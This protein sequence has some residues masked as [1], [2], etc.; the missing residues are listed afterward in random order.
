MARSTTIGVSVAAA[1]VLAGC[2]SARAASE[3]PSSARAQD[4]AHEHRWISIAKEYRQAVRDGDMERVDALQAPDARIWFGERKGDGRALDP[5]GRGPWAQWDT[6]FRARSTQSDFV[7]VDGAVRFTNRETNDWYRLVERAPRPYFIFYF[8][9]ENDR[10]SGKLI[11]SIEGL[12]R[13][14]DRLEEF[15]VWAQ[16]RHPGLLD[17]LMPDGEIDPHLD[18]ARVWK[19]RLLEWRADAGLPDVLKDSEKPR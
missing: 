3:V 18:K 1:I 19:A 12:K 16:E 7:I 10:I 4:G 2:V 11:Q 14:T 8:F 15:K 9:D 5:R 13:P 17:T 6:F